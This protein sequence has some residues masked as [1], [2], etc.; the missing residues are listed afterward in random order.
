VKCADIIQSKASQNIRR[1]R[2]FGEKFYH[3]ATQV[4]LRHRFNTTKISS[5][6]SGP[7]ATAATTEA[8]FK[9]KAGTCVTSLQDETTLFPPK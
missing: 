8:I 7:A 3:L 9:A 5:E 4:L 2:F 6:R 1:L